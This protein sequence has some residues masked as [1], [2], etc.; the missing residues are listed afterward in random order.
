M[1]QEWETWLTHQSID[2]YFAHLD[3]RRVQKIFP[4]PKFKKGAKAVINRVIILLEQARNF[5]HGII[6]QTF[7]A[8][9]N[10][11]KSTGTYSTYILDELQ[12]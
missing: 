6:K 4:Q 5:A 12:K 7:Q 1:N 11:G 9:T 2:T 10:M 3:R 8:S